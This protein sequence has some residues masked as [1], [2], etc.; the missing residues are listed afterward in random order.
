MEPNPLGAKQEPVHLNGDGIGSGEL[1]SEVMKPEEITA[2][3]LADVLG[4]D[5]G[6]IRQESIGDGLVGMNVR[7]TL[8]DAAPELPDSVVIKLPSLDLTSRATG[9]ALRIYEREVKFYSSV[10]NTVDIRVPHCHHATWNEASGDFV[11]VLED[12][13]P[14]HQG[15]Q[16]TGC[17]VDSAALAVVALA[18][19]HGPRW[20]DPS[21]GDLEWL[22]RRSGSDDGAQLGA[23]WQMF[24]AGFAE[25][26]RGYLTTEQFELA[27]Q[28]G[29]VIPA[30]VDGRDGPETITHGD[31]RLD[32]MLFGVDAGGPPITVVDWQTPG[33]GSP[34]TDLSYFCGAGLLPNDRGESERRLVDMYAAALTEYG[35]QVDEAWLW[36]HY[37]REA[38][39]GVVMAVVASQVVGRS[40]RSEA[41]FAAMATRHLQHALETDSLSLV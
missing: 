20:N 31:Y 22:D 3:W 34:A 16:I 41:M 24:F 27:E 11:I 7:V 13:A 17:S 8:T 18:H 36:K 29:P 15:D 5:V 10:A 35:V 19:L 6:S 32:N 39:A 33:H 23:L 14:A 30:W 4:G 28:F 25:T 1:P 2:D 26:Y 38:F 37:R 12:M 40:D 21:L 9:I